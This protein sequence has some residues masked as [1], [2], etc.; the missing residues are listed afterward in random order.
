MR[1][2]LRRYSRLLQLRPQAVYA[3]LSD[4]DAAQAIKLLVVVGL[5]AGLGVWLGVPA[6]LRQLTLPEQVDQAVAA[7]RETAEQVGAAVLPVILESK[8]AVETFVT[9]V[10]QQVAAVVT[11]ANSFVSG[12]SAAFGAQREQVTQNA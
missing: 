5:I 11:R 8:S 12:I 6:A 9:L 7:A 1:Q 4:Y 2:A 3:Y 10:Q